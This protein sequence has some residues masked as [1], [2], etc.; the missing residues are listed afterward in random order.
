M[1]QILITAASAFDEIEDLSL[2]VVYRDDAGREAK[3]AF[4]V[5]YGKP[6]DVST[7]HLS[8]P[9]SLSLVF[10][11]GGKELQT[12]PVALQSLP[13]RLEAKIDNYEHTIEIK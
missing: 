8:L 13:H 4:D 6:T 5:E 2:A 9:A 7:K 11:A 10:S 3:T 1:T 12:L